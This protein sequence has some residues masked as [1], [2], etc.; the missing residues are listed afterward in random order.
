MM[1]REGSTIRIRRG[2]KTELDPNNKQ[3]R[4]F[5]RCAGTS[6]FVWNWGLATWKQWY[7]D[8]KKGSGFRLCKHFN[9]IK[10]EQCPWIREMP[11]AVTEAAFRDLDTAFRNFFRRVKK[12]ADKVGY[13]KFKSRRNPKQSFALRGT[14][15]ARDRVR[16]THIGWVRLKERG[17]LPTNDNGAKLGTYSVVSCRAGRWYISV[18][19]EEEIAE[20][21]LDTLIVGVDFGIKTLATLSNGETFENPHALIKAERKL[22]RLNKELARRK[23]K[24]ANW[25]KTKEKLGRQYA[26]VTNLRNH[27]LHEIS[28]H[29]TM[30]LRPRV[31]VLEDLNVKGMLSNRHLSKAI[32][33]VGF[34]ELRRQIE[35][36]AQWC[37]I[38]VVVADRWYAS[39]KTCSACGWKNDA[40]ALSNRIFSCPN[41]GLELDRDLNA[42]INLQRLAV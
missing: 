22:A 12:G 20:P 19:V 23:H 29:V 5:M 1:E 40:L 41:C 32:A 38:E 28:H 36:K 7:E 11:Y 3:Q 8:S 14:K 35:Y 6:R 10:D 9:A 33:D 42:A 2:Y 39:S 4:F 24:S 21:Q 27:V 25:K 30:E 37:G 31:I 18:Q 17:Y 26:R 34:S 15:V 16:L 13:P